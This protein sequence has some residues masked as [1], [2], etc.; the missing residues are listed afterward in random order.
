MAAGLINGDV[1]TVA[2][3]IHPKIVALMGGVT[4]METLAK[5]NMA[6]MKVVDITFGKPSAVVKSGKEL[7]CVL[8]QTATVQLPQGSMKGNSSLIAFSF[9]GGKKWVFADT[10]L[11]IDRIRQVIPS[12]SSKLVIP[13]QQ[14][15][16]MLK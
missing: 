8:P 3:H 12:I 6:T 16:T 13:T 1:K 7:Q 9:D 15:P 5:N 10:Q 14:P 4:R 2:A 11:G